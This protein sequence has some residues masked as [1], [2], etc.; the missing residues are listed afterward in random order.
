MKE[1][2][3]KG[4]WRELV[5]SSLSKKKKSLYRKSLRKTPLCKKP[6]QKKSLQK[7]SLKETFSKETF[8]KETSSKET[9]SKETSLKEKKNCQ[10]NAWVMEKHGLGTHNGKMCPESWFQ[11]MQILDH[12]GKYVLWCCGS[13]SQDFFTF[14]VLTLTSKTNPSNRLG[15]PWDWLLC[16]GLPKAKIFGQS[17]S[18]LLFG[19]RLWLPKF[20]SKYSAFGFVLKMG[21]YPFFSSW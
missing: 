1:S 11:L 17:Q 12:L 21:H 2:L 18:F 7:R 14:T 6:P 13:R 16:S 3:F 5:Y 19:L 4:Y 10:N 9:S 8:S 15:C 20:Y